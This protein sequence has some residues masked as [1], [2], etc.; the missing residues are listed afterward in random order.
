MRN[1]IC[2]ILGLFALSACSELPGY[3]VYV[4]FFPR[5]CDA[6]VVDEVPADNVSLRVLVSGKEAEHDAAIESLAM[7][8]YKIEHPQ[9]RLVPGGSVLEAVNYTTSLCTG[10]RILSQGKDIS[11]SFSVQSPRGSM[12]WFNKDREIIH[13]PESGMSISAFLNLSP[14]VPVSFVLFTSDI[15]KPASHPVVVELDVDNSKT[16]SYEYLIKAEQ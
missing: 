10:L 13:I 9:L 2:F 15:N 3:G 5:T 12:C 11:D 6:I 8:W 16:L 4:D 1:T 7:E 14:L